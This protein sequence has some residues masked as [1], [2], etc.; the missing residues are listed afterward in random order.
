MGLAAP[1]L[2]HIPMATDMQIT[3][4][5]LFKGGVISDLHQ[6]IKGVNSAVQVSRSAVSRI[7]S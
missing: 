2:T 7:K 4:D 3:T 6:V 1:E 5:E